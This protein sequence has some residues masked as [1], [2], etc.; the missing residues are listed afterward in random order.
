MARAASKRS[1]RRTGA[2]ITS[3][4]TTH[5]AIVRNGKATIDDLSRF[6]DGTEVEI[7]VIGD[8]DELTVT[9][10][11]ELDAMLARSLEDEKAGRTRPAADLIAELRAM[12]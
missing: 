4:L 1:T 5:R 11:R 6:P 10:L 2:R 7:A 8:A 9:E 12:R 3:R